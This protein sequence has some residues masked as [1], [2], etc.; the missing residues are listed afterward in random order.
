MSPQLFMGEEPSP[1]DDLYAVG[2]TLYELLT[3]KPPF[4]GDDLS[5]QILEVIPESMAERRRHSG[6]PESALPAGLGG[7]DRRLSGQ[8]SAPR[9]QSPAMT[10][11]AVWDSPCRR[12]RPWPSTARAAREARAFS[13][14]EKMGR[15]SRR[16]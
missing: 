7:D 15:R 16:F 12:L 5:T 2:A 13:F 1:S 4:H 6:R 9:G 10:S 8:R 14:A 11:P 3:G